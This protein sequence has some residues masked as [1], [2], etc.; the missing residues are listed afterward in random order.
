MG[1]LDKFESSLDRMVNG[2]FAKAFRADVQPVEIA[3]AVQKEM[4]ERA[5][6]VSRARTVV[7][8]EFVVH[9]SDSDY[10]RL[11]TYSEVLNTELAELAREYAQ[12]QRYTFLGPVGVDLAEDD[13]MATGVFRVSSQATAGPGAPPPV[14]A[15]P[16]PVTRPAKV[17]PPP[18]RPAPVAGSRPRLLAAGQDIPLLGATTVLGRGADVD[19]RLEDPGVSRRHAQI[20]VADGRSTISDLGST[21]G[22]LVDG[23]KVTTAVLADGA[24]IRL[25]STEIT[26]RSS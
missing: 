26:F 5:A 13:A 23:Q 20:T 2:A 14:S 4:D 19:I 7:P 9:L 11:A 22:T 16:T 17:T 12:E 25:G 15:P 3:A 24:V 8:N 1:I 18:P 6:V 10:A 21:N